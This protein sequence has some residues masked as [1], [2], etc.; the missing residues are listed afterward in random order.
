[1]AGRTLESYCYTPYY[2]EENVWHLCRQ[3]SL[4][5]FEKEAVF[6]SN[7]QR[8][9][10]LW[11]QKAAESGM[12]VCW[13]Y[14]VIL[15][16]RQGGWK[17]WD[18]DSRLD[19]PTAFD[20]YVR[21]TFAVRPLHYWQ[22]FPPLFRVLPAAEFVA[23]FDSDRSHM[24]TPQQ[25]WQAPPP[26]WPPIRCRG[27]YKLQDLIDMEQAEPGKVLTLEELGSCFGSRG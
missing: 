19:L 20:P 7:P 14:H 9:C 2:C 4:S 15:A 23:K 17:V 5:A 21:R 24:R 13:D 11:Q 26:A 27:G 25:G 22:E 12:P 8:A 3:P 6:I 16:V 1:M 18:L 10:S